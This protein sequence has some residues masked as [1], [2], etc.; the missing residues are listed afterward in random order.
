MVT[1][2]HYA[3]EW[4]SSK[5]WSAEVIA[6]ATK[7]LLS[8]NGLM[9]IAE[10]NGIVFP[11]NP[12]T[13]SHVSGETYGGFRPQSCPIGAP[14]SKHKRGLAV[15]LYDPHGD[16]DDWC[17]Q[18]EDKLKQYGIWIEHPSKTVHWSHWQC[19]KYGSYVEGK[20]RWFYP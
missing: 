11:V 8:V 6:N 10:D 17:M 1:L 20:H 19:V 5:D 16:I 15:D 3:G 9:K 14:Q 4:K 18:N 13:G 2:D 7:L 12:R